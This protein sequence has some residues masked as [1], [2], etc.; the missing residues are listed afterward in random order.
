LCK[1]LIFRLCILLSHAVPVFYAGLGTLNSK[2]R[3]ILVRV[4]R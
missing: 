1:Q 4:S 2:L 3:D